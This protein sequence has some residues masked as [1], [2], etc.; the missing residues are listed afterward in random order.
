MATGALVFATVACGGGGMDLRLA[1]EQDLG[2]L[3]VRE[4]D[5][6]GPFT[7]YDAGLTSS[8]DIAYRVDFEPEPLDRVEGTLCISNEINLYPSV[9]HAVS[10]LGELQQAVEEDANSEE[11]YDILV[12]SGLVEPSI[13]FR[14]AKQ[15]PFGCFTKAEAADWYTVAVQRSNVI[16]FIVLWSVEP[17]DT[18][19]AV[20]LANLQAER[21][22]SVL[23]P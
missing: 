21:I 23:A 16:T 3:A 15:E 19:Q 12:P 18:D 5:V 10:R 17:D 2:D 13:A 11:G 7:Y 6:E 14:F 22:E 1:V 4:G 9:E 20:S 8:G